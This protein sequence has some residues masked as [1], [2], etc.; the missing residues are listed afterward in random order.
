[1]ALSVQHAPEG[2][3]TAPVEPAPRRRT[4]LRGLGIGGVS[5]LVAGT[6]L[7]SYRALDNGVLDSG[8]GAPYDAWDHWRSDPGPLGTVAAAIL[9]ANPH[10]TQPWV[11]RVDQHSPHAVVDLFSDPTRALATIDPLRREH[12]VGL[13]CAL[14]N[15]VL[16]AGARGYRAAVT[17]VPVGA[18]PAHVARVVLSPG[19]PAAAPA[20]SSLYDAI[21]DRHS[22]RGPYRA[23]PMTADLLTAL[24]AQ[25]AGL[26]GVG[27]RWLA[28]ATE[29]SAM[30]SLILDATRA[31]VN[32]TS[33][34]RQAFAWFRNDRDDIDRHR[35]GLTLDGQGLDPVTLTLGKLLPA[36][37][38]TAGDQ[39]WLTQTE[40]VHTATAAAY[41]VITVADPDDVVSRL[42]GGRL[43]QRIHLAATANGIALQHLNQITERIDPDRTQGRPPTVAA[44]FS[45]IL[46]RPGRLPL[47]TFR[48]GFPRRAARRSPRRSLRAVTA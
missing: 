8:A 38:R 45:E 12:H 24:S 5:V 44:R 18:D 9:A 25:T 3:A 39:F 48:V 33:Q 17:L 22:N 2:R 19:A 16:A 10:N 7:A 21:G 35:D 40:T 20:E 28:A 36:S 47:V 30:R 27:V 42:D 6:G 41:G 15:L 29:K 4:V 26:P 43:L 13:G 31:I 1:M 46:D 34:S 37:S 11:F 14:E 32:D 23:A